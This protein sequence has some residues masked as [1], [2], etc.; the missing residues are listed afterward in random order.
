VTTKQEIARFHSRIVANPEQLVDS[1]KAM[2]SELSTQKSHIADL[3]S[4][5]KHRAQRNAAFSNAG[6]ELSKALAKMNE[7]SAL[8]DKKNS[9]ELQ[10][11]S[12][13]ENLLKREQYSME[14]HQKELQMRRQLSSQQEKIDKLNVQQTQKRSVIEESLR[15]L[16]EEYEVVTKE[17]NAVQDKIDT[18]ERLIKEAE[19]NVLL[20]SVYPRLLIFHCLDT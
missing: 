3:E 17:R 10:L 11:L 20:S 16:R 15:S 4:R 12:E 13:R 9:L 8:L 5:S 18:N 1:L 19:T 7:C 14:I 6:D 2:A